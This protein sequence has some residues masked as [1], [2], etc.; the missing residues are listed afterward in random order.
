[1]PPYCVPA[2]SVHSRKYCSEKSPNPPDHPACFRQN[3]LNAGLWQHKFHSSKTQHVK[4][5]QWWK[6]HEVSK[7]GQVPAGLGLPRWELSR[8]EVSGIRSGNLQGLV[9]YYNFSENALS[10]VSA[11]EQP[12]SQCWSV[13]G[14][15]TQS[16][17]FT[18]P[19]NTG[20][21]DS[22]GQKPKHI[23]RF[24]SESNK[25]ESGRENSWHSQHSQLAKVE[26][27]NSYWMFSLCCSEVHLWLLHRHS[28]STE[29]QRG[30]FICLPR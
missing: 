1:M 24:Y 29:K 21:M 26:W 20:A 11:S 4:I 3:S 19:L 6:I 5:E 22:Q 30:R 23:L 27:K 2:C 9:L 18:L 12:G 7:R 25:E 14:A 28:L 10:L 13:P 16:E 17:I 8:P 15:S